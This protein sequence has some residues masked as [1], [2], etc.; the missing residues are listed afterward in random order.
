MRPATSL[1]LVAAGAI[2][3][4]AVR[5][6]PSFL[7]LQVAGL[8]IIVVGVAGMLLPGR[9]NQW[10]R[11]R[12]VHRRGASQPL[13]E[14]IVEHVDEDVDETNYPSYVMIN[15]DALNSVQ[16]QGPPLDAEP[17]EGGAPSI[18]NLPSDDL[19]AGR[20]GDTE[21]VEEYLEE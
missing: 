18:M 7:N 9:G 3:A 12:I 11:R 15:P 6:H 2:L 13:A 8:V 10:L 16:P 17:A 19:A 20:R 21:V 14:H 1:A 4:F 5:A